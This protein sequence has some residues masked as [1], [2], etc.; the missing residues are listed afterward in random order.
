MV[1]FYPNKLQPAQVQ[2]NKTGATGSL[3]V[4]ET[5]NNGCL[6]NPASINVSLFDVSSAKGLNK[7]AFGARNFYP[8]P[9]ADKLTIEVNIGDMVN[10]SVYDQM[11]R[12]VLTDIRFNESL[13]LNTQA[14]AA[15]IYTAKLTTDR[16]NTTVL[17]FEIK[18]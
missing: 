12:V 2:W 10:L 4:T 17:G 9:S 6:G 16:G 7:N 13:L 5:G 1:L 11:G 18:N 14:L 8:N 3:T 15:G